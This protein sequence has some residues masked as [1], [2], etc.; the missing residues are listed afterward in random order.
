MLNILDEK[1]T[2]S[3]L[4]GK[5][6]A[7]NFDAVLTQIDDENKTP[8]KENI[9]LYLYVDD[10]LRS[11]V[12]QP[13]GP[14]SIDVTPYLSTGTSTIK[15]TAAYTEVITSDTGETANVVIRN[16][17]RWYISVIDMYIKSTFDDSTDVFRAPISYS[18]TPM[19]NLK[20]SLL[21]FRWK[22][23]WKR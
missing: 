21:Y 11:T 8:L 23:K 13:A 18:Y 3:I 10:V 9:T 17:K 19:G 22:K 6:A 20:D 7:I 12:V 4:K 5:S 16:T 1:N 15:L 2:F 14:G